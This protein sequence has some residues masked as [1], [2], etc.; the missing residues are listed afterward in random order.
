LKDSINKDLSYDYE[1]NEYIPDDPFE[2]EQRLHFS[3]LINDTVGLNHSIGTKAKCRIN[4]SL[5][6]TGILIIKPSYKES[7][8]YYE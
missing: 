6:L 3:N 7:K 4:D 5:G 8:T 1:T 2:Y